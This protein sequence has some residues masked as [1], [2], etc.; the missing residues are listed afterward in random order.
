MICR[1]KVCTPRLK[2]A[3]L[4]LRIYGPCSN[5][6]LAQR[7]NRSPER[8]YRQ[9]YELRESGLAKATADGYDVTDRGRALLASEFDQ[10]RLFQ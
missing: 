5:A 8:V 1:V 2:A 9:V 4:G 3:L 10:G 7:I 6:E